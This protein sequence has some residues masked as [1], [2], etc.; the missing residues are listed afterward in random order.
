MFEHQMGKNIEVYIDDMVVKNKLAPNHIDDLGDVFQVLR[1]YKLR[2]N[3]TKCSFG[4]GSGK[5][6]GYMVTHR[7]IEANPDQI[8]AIHNLQP[9]RNPKEAQKLTGMIAALNR[10]ISRSAD[11]CRPFF[12]LLHKWKGFEWN[13]ECATA[14]QQLKEYLAQPPIMSSPKADE[15]LFAYIAVAP[16]AVSLV[17]IREDNGTQRPVYYVSKS[18]QEAETCYL[19]LEK[20]ILAIVLA[21]L[22][23]EFAEPTSEGKEVLVLLGAGERVSNTVSPHG[24]A[25]WKAYIN[26]ASN[27]RGSGLELVLLSPGGITI[28][29]SL[30]LDFSATNNE[31]EYEAL[32]EGMGMVRKMGGKSV[33]MFLDSRLIVR[34]VNGDMKAKDERMQEYLVQ[35]KHLQ[36]Q[37]HHFRL[38]HVPRSGNTH[39]DSLATLATSSAQP[40]PRVILV[41]E[42]LRPL[43]GK[44]NGIGIHNARA[45][46]S[47]MD[48]IVLYLKHDTLPDDKIEA[49]KIRR[50]T[51][52]F[53]LSEDSKLY[54]RSFSGPY[55]LCVHPEAAELILEELHEGIC[56]SHTGG[57][58]LSHRALTQGHWW[59]SMKKEAMDYVKKC[60]QCQRYA[61]SIHQPGGELNP[62]SSPWPFAQ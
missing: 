22:V 62:M 40:L 43:T 34:Q 7:G 14:F 35:V 36:T 21:D 32:L 56:R 52:R 8:R 61:P 28:E 31:A 45:G 38:T 57:R 17:L 23:A 25:W 11:R 54:R 44:A 46:P 19:P 37:F 1:K 20:A 15:V 58:S 53:W 13:E 10:F 50:R 41:E 26:G 60:D 24:L 12:L 39:A 18:L 55:L 4:V 27:Q 49:G 48:P 51:T 30:R 42:V 29:K 59:P 9:P 6:L 3:A 5:F 33:D 2:L 16:H 47:W